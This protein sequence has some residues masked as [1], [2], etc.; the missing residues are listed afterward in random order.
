MMNKSLAI[1]GVGYVGLPLAIEF[2]KK[3]KVKVFDPF[4]DR[5]LELQRGYD[6]N[7]ETGKKDLLKNSSRINFSSDE[8]ILEDTEIFIITVPTPVDKNN[9]P[10]L[11]PLANATK[12]VAKYINR[13]SIV[14]FESTVFPGACEEICVPILEEISGLK[15]KTDFHCGYSPE[16]INPGDKKRTLTNT[17]KI[18]SGSSEE[19]LNEIDLLYSSIIKAGTFKASSLKVA[20]AAKLIENIQR[21]ANIAIVNE[22][23]SFLENI[24]VSSNEVFE[25]ASTKWNFLPFKPGLV[26]GHCISVDPYYYIYKAEQ[27]GMNPKLIN[28]AR[29]VN[30]EMPSVICR[31]MLKKFEKKNI[32]LSKSRLLILGFSFKENTSDIRNTKI[33]DIVNMLKEKKIKVD[34]ADPICSKKEV[35]DKYKI[36]L[37]DPKENFYDAILIAVPHDILVKKGITYFQ[38]LCNENKLIFDLKS[39]FP[40]AE[41]IF[42]L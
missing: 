36:D 27:V 35:K 33:N 39:V 28:A 10:D 19:I 2:S 16:R 18:V 26:G 25:A 32:E 9:F 7:G 42:R 21:D 6:R 12:T 23:S 17:Q 8:K 31:W 1:I 24:D 40:K 11:N 20:E 37:V 14:I 5:I 38:S 41:G 30:N 13:N 15:Y 22:Y 34:V 29:E 3:R 4:E